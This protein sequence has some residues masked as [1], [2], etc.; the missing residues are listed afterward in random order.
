MDYA[1]PASKLASL[2]SGEFVGRVADSPNEKIELKMFHCEI[3]NDHEEI[4]R[5]EAHYRDISTSVKITQQDID[6]NYLKIKNDVVE[7]IQTKLNKVNSVA[8]KSGR[9]EP[10]IRRK[11]KAASNSRKAKVLGRAV[12]M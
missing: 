11:A 4:K 1:I 12:S 5:Q 9:R 6:E 8:E 7:L 10:P 2:S 3:Q